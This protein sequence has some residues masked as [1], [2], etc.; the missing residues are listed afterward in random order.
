VYGASE[1]AFA[2]MQDAYDNMSAGVRQARELAR[3]LAGEKDPHG[4]YRSIISSSME[5]SKVVQEG[6]DRLDTLMITPR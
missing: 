5:H 6:L 3:S 2:A 4:M 1:K